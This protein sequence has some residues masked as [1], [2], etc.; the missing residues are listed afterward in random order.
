[1]GVAGLI[2]AALVL[3]R[4]IIPPQAAFARL[5]PALEMGG[6]FRVVTEEQ[7]FPA[8]AG[9]GPRRAGVS[10]FGFGGTNCHL[11]L[12]E[13]PVAAGPAGRVPVP[14]AGRAGGGPVPR[15]VRP[16][17][18]LPRP[19]RRAGRAAGEEALPRRALRPPGGGARA[20]AHRGVPAGHGGAGAGARRLRARA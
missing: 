8:P 12:D 17:P 6:R 13:P 14:G 7:P 3:N 4:R 10:S 20:H 19:A 2:K 11:V 9:G 15:A 1:A 18:A 5:N 16:L